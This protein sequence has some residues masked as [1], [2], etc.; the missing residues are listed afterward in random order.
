MTPDRTRGRRGRFR[1]CRRRLKFRGQPLLGKDRFVLPNPRIRSV[2]FQR[3]AEE[4]GDVLCPSSSE[5][6][7]HGGFGAAGLFSDFAAR[8]LT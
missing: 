8:L 6:L 5:A 7:L 2:R 3:F 4:L 1:H